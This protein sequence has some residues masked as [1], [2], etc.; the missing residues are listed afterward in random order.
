M[1]GSATVASQNSTANQTVDYI[2][3]WLDDLYGAV[4]V[5]WCLVGTFGNLLSIKYF[6]RE[7][8]K[9]SNMLYLWMIGVDVTTCVS[10]LHFGVA[11]IYPAFGEHFLQ[12]GLLCNIFG[13]SYNIS[14]RLSVFVVALQSILRSYSLVCPFRKIRLRFVMIAVSGMTAVQVF[15]ASLPYLHLKKY[16]FNTHWSLCLWY[17]DDICPTDSKMYNILYILILILPF[18][19]P[20]VPV[21]ISCAV[22]IR[23]IGGNKILDIAGIATSPKS[24]IS[25]PIVDKLCCRYYLPEKHKRLSVTPRLSQLSSVVKSR[26]KHR[27]TVTILIITSTYII[28]NMPY[29]VY[30][31]YYL[32]MPYTFSLFDLYLGIFLNPL[33]VILNAAINPVVYYLR[34]SGMKT[35][36]TGTFKNIQFPRSPRLRKKS[37]FCT[38]VTVS[39]AAVSRVECS[40]VVDRRES[41]VQFHTSVNRL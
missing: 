34:I 26:L 18:L 28:L 2:I 33:C 12:A 21:L 1:N 8:K 23:F 36:M 17:L 4:S 20:A 3:P 30:L 35:H 37:I 16:E 29:W 19:L 9:V 27:A 6:A 32:I 25:T 5:L 7:W 15:Q 39:E 14:S 31:T 41:V 38:N 24:T 13:F 10:M 11:R 22:S 40:Y